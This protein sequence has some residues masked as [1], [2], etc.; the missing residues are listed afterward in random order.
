MQKNTL[1]AL[2]D[3]E[4]LQ[5]FEMV[6]LKGGSFSME[7]EAG[8]RRLNFNC[9]CNKNECTIYNASDKCEPPKFD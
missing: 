6:E 5:E 4:V 3:E 1:L 8:G 9:P 7:L 2:K